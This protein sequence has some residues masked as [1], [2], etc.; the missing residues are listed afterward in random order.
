MNM[1]CWVVNK[2]KFRL[3]EERIVSLNKEQFLNSSTI[4]SYFTRSS[5]SLPANIFK[6]YNNSKRSGIELFTSVNSS[7]FLLPAESFSKLNEFKFDPAAESFTKINDSKQSPYATTFSKQ[8][9]FKYAPSPEIFKSRNDGEYNGPPLLFKSRNDSI[10]NENATLFNGMNKEIYNSF[11]KFV[12]SFNEQ[13]YLPNT[14]PYYVTPTPFYNIS[15][16]LLYKNDSLFTMAGLLNPAFEESLQSKIS[17]LEK[18]VSLQT[19]RNVNK[20]IDINQQLTSPT[21]FSQYFI[22]E[23]ETH[24]VTPSITGGLLDQKISFKIP[25]PNEFETHGVTPSITGGLLDQKIGMIIPFPPEFE[26]H[27]VLPPLTGVLLDQKIRIIIPFPPEFEKHGI[28]PPLTGALFNQKIGMI[29]PFPPEF[30]KHGVLPPLQGQLL[31]QRHGLRIAVPPELEYHGIPVPLPP[32]LE[33]HGIPVPFVPD[34]IL[35]IGNEIPLPPEFETHGVLPPLNG[36]VL[37]QRH[38]LR[39]DLPVDKEYH[40]I[41]VPLPPEIEYHGIPVPLPPEIEYHGIPVLMPSE[42]LNNANTGKLIP[43]PL[44]RVQDNTKYHT[45]KQNWELYQ[46]IEWNNDN[47]YIYGAFMTNFKIYVN[48]GKDSDYKGYPPFLSYGPNSGSALLSKNIN[49]GLGSF[50]NP[51]AAAIVAAKYISAGVIQIVGTSHWNYRIM[52]DK[53][54]FAPTRS[55]IFPRTWYIRG[56]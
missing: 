13:Q 25:L 28:M 42:R 34:L 29:I 30:E 10:Y 17:I 6:W 21:N 39:I 1:I 24:G 41:P 53:K 48:E 4:F 45:F 40:G 26:K 33:Y 37:V 47:P 11:L 23:F 22:N 20:F 14:K 16:Q 46:E 49:Y 35:Q 8:N 54:V 36:E 50:P 12:T 43:M 3:P 19:L 9:D 15:N 27:G 31:V 2:T 5:F 52:F 44:L 32:E 51:N 18:D 7:K 55:M 38:G 56:A